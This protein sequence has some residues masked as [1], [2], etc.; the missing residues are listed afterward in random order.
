MGSIPGPGRSHLLWGNE[1]CAL[2]PE[3]HN[4]RTHV[5]QLL[6]PV[7]PKAHA[8]QQEEPPQWEAHEM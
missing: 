1:A 4:Y 7:H 5:P 3:S 6:K 2:G 8:L